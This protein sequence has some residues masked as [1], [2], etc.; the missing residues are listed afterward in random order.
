MDEYIYDPAEIVIKEYL[1]SVQSAPVVGNVPKERPAQFVQLEVVGGGEGI[2][3]Q[4]PMVTFI[5]WDVS[6]SAAASFAAEIK[7]HLARCRRLGGLP[8]YRIATIGLPVFRPDPDTKTARYQF[9]LEFR[10]RGKKFSP[11]P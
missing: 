6:R 7:A 2:V 3:T 11:S 10:V 5:C 1:K 8:V 4:H 9:T